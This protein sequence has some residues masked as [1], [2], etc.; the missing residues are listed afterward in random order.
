MSASDRRAKATR[1]G[2]RAI[3]TDRYARWR[4]ETKRRRRG[5]TRDQTQCMKIIFP[6]IELHI[7]T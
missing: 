1:T 7:Y 2:Q 3:D 6:L 4:K 5:E